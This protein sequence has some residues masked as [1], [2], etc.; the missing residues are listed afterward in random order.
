MI[1]DRI[2]TINFSLGA[3]D[4]NTVVKDKQLTP[5]QIKRE[6]LLALR[7]S[8]DEIVNLHDFEVQY[9]VLYHSEQQ[10]YGPV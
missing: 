8:L 7:P 2:P 4:P 9:K 6:E 10:S 3:V 1:G 5:E